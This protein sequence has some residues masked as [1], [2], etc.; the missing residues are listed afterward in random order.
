MPGPDFH[1]C[2]VIGFWNI[3]ERLISSFLFYKGEN[4][5]PNELRHLP[6]F[7]QSVCDRVQRLSRRLLSSRLLHQIKTVLAQQQPFLSIQLYISTLDSKASCLPLISALPQPSLVTVCL[8]LFQWLWPLP[9]T[10]DLQCWLLLTTF[11]LALLFYSLSRTFLFPALLLS[12]S[13]SLFS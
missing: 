6:I 1:I 5:N 3:L 12:V 11:F 2:H 13:L 7:S 4:G 9:S 8:W 10:S